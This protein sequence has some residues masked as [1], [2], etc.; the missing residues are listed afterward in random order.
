MDLGSL[1]HHA[2]WWAD[3]F[4]SSDELRRASGCFGLKITDK[5]AK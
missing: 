4:M 2:Q 1:K 3:I 5:V